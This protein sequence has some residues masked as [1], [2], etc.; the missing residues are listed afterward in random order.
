MRQRPEKGVERAVTRILAKGK[1][2]APVDVLVDRGLLAPK[3]L[4]DWRRGKGPKRRLR[5]TKTGEPNLEEAHARH[6]VCPWMTRGAIDLQ[7]RRVVP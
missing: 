7:K 4:E 3:K 1:V 2:V 6:F 5:F